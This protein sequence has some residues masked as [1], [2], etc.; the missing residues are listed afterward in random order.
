MEKI[1]AQN[2]SSEER[3]R[4]LWLV[5]LLLL[6]GAVGL[7]FLAPSKKSMQKNTHVAQ[8]SA[9]STINEASLTRVNRY[10]QLAGKA[11]E[12]QAEKTDIENKLSTVAIDKDMIEQSSQLPVAGDL[13]LLFS[14]EDYA[15]KIANDLKVS[16][17]HSEVDFPNLPEDRLNQKIKLRQ[18]V[19]EY[20]QDYKRRYVDAFI[21]NARKGGFAVQLNDDLQVIGVKRIARPEPL[22]F[23]QST[24]QNA[25]L[26]STQ[27]TN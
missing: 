18:W 23:P 2:N 24:S 21:E 4:K 6:L 17:P 11:I 3:E 5:V 8:G 14:Q 25:S 19:R 10:M 16:D 12:V 1:K 9:E 13:G 20:D 15:Q 27:G 7:V 22:R 26:P